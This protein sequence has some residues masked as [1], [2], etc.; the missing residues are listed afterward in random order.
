MREMNLHVC[1]LSETWDLG[2]DDF[3][4][5]HI[6]GLRFIGVGAVRGRR[7]VA[8]ALRK[9]IE[10]EVLRE[11]WWNTNEA[12]GVVLRIRETIIVSVYVPNGRVRDGMEQTLVG[13]QNVY[14]KFPNASFVV[15]G[16]FNSRLYA[17]RNTAGRILNEFLSSSPDFHR[18][19]I[20]V[21]TFKRVSTPDHMICAN[22]Y[23]EECDV[24]EEMEGDSDHL[25]MFCA[26]K[27]LAALPIYDESEVDFLDESGIHTSQKA[28]ASSSS[29]F[30]RTTDSRTPKTG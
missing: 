7:G 11:L 18:A 5:A 9:H 17:P 10:C 15:L 29:G 12:I 4:D 25:P 24:F 16:D 6:A 30:S 28:A 19:P 26:I 27:N 3:Y 21:P 2:F 20:N 14:S 1:C 22:T 8:I 13:I 23:F